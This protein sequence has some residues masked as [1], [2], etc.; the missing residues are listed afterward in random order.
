MLDDGKP[1]VP[2]S[3][4]ALRFM[5]CLGVGLL[6]LGW[7]LG[8]ALGLSFG[9]EGF[10]LGGL[11]LTWVG[12]RLPALGLA[13]CPSSILMLLSGLSALI[14][15]CLP[16]AAFGACLGAFLWLCG[17]WLGWACSCLGGLALACLGACFGLVL[18]AWGGWCWGVGCGSG[19][20]PLGAALVFAFC[21]ANHDDD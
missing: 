16:L 17:L 20:S 2:P 6:A 4:L 3:R 5:D 12:W 13:L 15:A 8:L 9:S 19:S 18:G 14:G 21:F 7:L 10:S 1:I 11:A